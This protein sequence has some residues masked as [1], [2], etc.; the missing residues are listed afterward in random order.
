[1]EELLAQ[2]V[3]VLELLGVGALALSGE[4]LALLVEVLELWK[5]VVVELS[6]L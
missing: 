1:M 2:V 6:I 5:V 4:V 3:R